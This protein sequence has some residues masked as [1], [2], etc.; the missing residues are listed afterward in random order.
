MTDDPD[1][2]ALYRDHIRPAFAV[3]EGGHKAPRC[4]FVTGHQGSGKTALLRQLLV[5]LGERVTQSIVPD[6]LLAQIDADLA[7]PRA[8][9]AV[10]AYR[11]VHCATHCEKLADHAVAQRAH[12]LWERAIPGNIERLSQALR[13]LGYRVECVVLATPVEESWLATLARSLAAAQPYDPTA[14][15]VSWPILTDTAHRWPALLD[16]AEAD[17]TFDR[18]AI[19]SRDGEVCFENSTEGEPH[20]RHWQ[21]EPFA[22]ESLLVER[23]RPRSDAALAALLADWTDLHPRI[24]AEAHPAWPAHDLQAFDMHLRALVADPSSRFDLN[25]PD[26]ALAPGW[27]ARLSADLT[28]TLGSREVKDPASL[29]ARSRR[30]IAL[31]TQLAGQPMR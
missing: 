19:L 18:I 5:Q 14:L 26:P 6:A 28:A 27:I 4:I 25:A 9:A 11:A 16:R 1:W 30:L 20:S 12:I 31:V 8:K 21:S 2:D 10:Q 24:A 3:T 23:A 7:V 22:V 13:R 15:R 29:A 17:L